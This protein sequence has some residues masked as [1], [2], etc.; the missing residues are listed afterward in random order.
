MKIP[1][2]RSQIDYYLAAMEFTPSGRSAGDPGFGRFRKSDF[3]PPE[4]VAEEALQGLNYRFIQNYPGGTDIGIG[5]ACQLALRLPVPP[6]D[7][8][9]MVNYFSRHRADLKSKPYLAG[10]VTK[11]LVAHKLWGG[12]SGRDWA[13]EMQRFMSSY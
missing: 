12:W 2:T 10:K 9:R 13:L 11:G 7:I 3:V 5:R 4:E 6:R 8:D 1:L